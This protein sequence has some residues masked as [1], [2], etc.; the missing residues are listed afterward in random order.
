MIVNSFPSKQY[1]LA[2]RTG[3]SAIILCYNDFSTARS[4]E[5]LS[6]RK[7]HGKEKNAP[8]ERQ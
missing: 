6:N 4:K 5:K 1:I 7:I 8:E 3:T 2:E